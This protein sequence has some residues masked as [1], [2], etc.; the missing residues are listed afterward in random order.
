MTFDEVVKRM[1]LSGVASVRG[2]AVYVQTEM[3]RGA[4]KPTRASRPGDILYWPPSA[5]IL[6]VFA[7]GPPPPQAVKIGALTGDPQVLSK[8]RQGARIVIRRRGPA[9]SS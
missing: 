6:L 7:E 3:R 4:E 2:N 1:P 8:T 9:P 5:A